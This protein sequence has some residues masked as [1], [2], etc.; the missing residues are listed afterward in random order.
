[1]VET[2]EEAERQMELLLL[3]VPFFQSPFNRVNE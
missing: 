2:A 1:M 3:S